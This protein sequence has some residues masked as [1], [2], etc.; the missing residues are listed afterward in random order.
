MFLSH[1]IA[2]VVH[3]M[4]CCVNLETGVFF[5][6]AEQ[7]E[8][9]LLIESPR[10]FLHFGNTHFLHFW[11]KFKFIMKNVRIQKCQLWIRSGCLWYSL[12]F[13]FWTSYIYNYN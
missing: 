12:G 5:T 6:V 11:N 3:F 1:S 2:T 7:T 4:F 8:T 9:D 10:I 13:Y